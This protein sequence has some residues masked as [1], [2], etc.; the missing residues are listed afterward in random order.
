MTRRNGHDAV[1]KSI[2]RILEMNKLGAKIKLKINCVVM[3]GLNESGI[4]PFVELGREQD[5]EVRFIEYMPFDGN[6]WSEKKMISFDEMLALIRQK[7]P[8]VQKVEGHKNDTSKTYQV[9]G[10]AGRIGFIT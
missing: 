1:M 4:L 7:Y 9:P 3:R 2:N 5:I 10:F 6:K 8:D